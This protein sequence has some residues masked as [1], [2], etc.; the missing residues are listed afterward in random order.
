MLT[1]TQKEW[2][3]GGAVGAAALF[4]GYLLFRGRPAHAEG[5][6]HG[7]HRH[8]GTGDTALPGSQA[9]EQLEQSQHR[10]KH[11][12]PEGHDE[13]RV[14]DQEND[15]G[16]YGGKKK[17]KHHHRHDTETAIGKRPQQQLTF[18][19]GQQEEGPGAPIWRLSDRINSFVQKFGNV[20][21]SSE[22][23]WAKLN[24]TW[25]AE[26]LP[27]ISEW[28]PFWRDSSTWSWSGFD[29]WATRWNAL[30]ARLSQLLP[31]EGA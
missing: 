5:G 27:F 18:Q 13:D 24:P 30:S 11:R 3:V 6:E 2:V 1:D 9:Y 17:H 7:H 16:E 4:V 23:L 10:K 21:S 22:M 25:E 20:M 28:T 31:A 26:V 29:H 19:R 12:R 15:R 14:A 8:G